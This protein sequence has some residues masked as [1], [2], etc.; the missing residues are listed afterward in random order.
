MSATE[1]NQPK[2]DEIKSSDS[3]AEAAPSTEAPSTQTETKSDDK[4]AKTEETPAAAPAATQSSTSAQPSPSTSL[5]VGEL[6]PTVTEAMLYEIF[7]MVGPVASIRVCRDAVTRRS[8][9]YAYVNL[10]N[11]NDGESNELQAPDDKPQSR[12]NY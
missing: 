10:L 9:G 3:P 11:A 2:V 4:D 6:D 1:A 8:L 5:Y 12:W 7:S